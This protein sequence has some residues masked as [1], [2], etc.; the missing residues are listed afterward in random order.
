MTRVKHV[1]DAEFVLTHVGF[2]Q[3]DP[4]DA[5]K[6]ANVSHIE[7]GTFPD[8]LLRIRHF[9]V[10]EGRELKS[11]VQFEAE[12]YEV[13]QRNDGF[14]Y[15][16]QRRKAQTLMEELTVSQVAAMLDKRSAADDA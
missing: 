9:Y 8:Q 11:E 14:F 16:V 1:K 15:L 13:V 7:G 6:N 3:E 2:V 5:T 10:D 4:N 12:R